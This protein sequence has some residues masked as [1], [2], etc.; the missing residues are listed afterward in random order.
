MTAPTT[1]G[2]VG[3]GQMSESMAAFIAQGPRLSRKNLAKADDFS[4]P[5]QEAMTNGCRGFG[6]GDELIGHKTRSIMNL[7]MLAAPG[8]M[9]E[10]ETHFRG[11]IFRGAI[12]N[13]YGL[14]ASLQTGSAARARRGV[15]KLRAGNVASNGQDTSYG[16]PL[17]AYKQS[18]NGGEG[19]PPGLEEYLEIN[20]APSIDAMHQAGK[21]TQA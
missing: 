3:L 17:N 5:L 8:K 20:V 12:K 4:R 6:W 2:F 13:E 1:I 18:G 15:A 19:G 14:A 9:H 16:A 10:W 11:A 21:F 7:T